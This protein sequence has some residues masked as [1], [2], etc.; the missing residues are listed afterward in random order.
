MG[1]R[2]RSIKRGIVV[3]LAASMLFSSSGTGILAEKD[4]AQVEAEAAENETVEEAIVNAEASEGEEEKA[5]TAEPTEQPETKQEITETEANPAEEPKAKPEPAKPEA[6]PEETPETKA[7]TAEPETKPGPAETE[8]KSEET[9]ETKAEP[10]TKPEPAETEAD[11]EETPDTEAELGTKPE[12]AETEADP[13]ETP[14]TESESAE[15][16]TEPEGTPEVT[17]SEESPEWETALEENTEEIETEESG[18]AVNQKILYAADNSSDDLNLFVTDV[19]IEGAEREEDGSYKVIPEQP[20]EIKLSFAERTDLQ[21]QGNVLTYQ[22]PN[23]VTPRAVTDSAMSPP[24]QIEYTDDEGKEQAVDVG[25]SYSISGQIMTIT[26]V[27]NDPNHDKYEACANVYM[28]ITTEATISAENSRK[29][30]DFGNEKKITV[31]AEDVHE[32]T[33]EKEGTYDKETGNI[34]YTVE[35]K[36]KG[37]NTNVAVTDTLKASEGKICRLSYNGDLKASSDKEETVAFSTDNVSKTGF[38]CTIPVMKSGE[39]VTL[40]YS[41]A[42]D[43]DHLNGALDPDEAQNDITATSSE[44]NEVTPDTWKPAQ[45]EISH[46]SINKWRGEWLLNN[47]DIRWW[48]IALNDDYKG[49]LP[50][51]VTDWTETGKNQNGSLMPGNPQLTCQGKGLAV[52]IY[53]KGSENQEV[54]EEEITVAWEDL[55]VSGEKLKSGDPYKRWTYRIPEKYRTGNYRCVINYDAGVKIDDNCP[56]DSQILNWAE[57]SYGN[58]SGMDVHI[59]N[60]TFGKEAV[61]VT[62][63]EV[64]WRLRINVPAA[65]LTECVV[66]DTLPSKN[67]LKDGNWKMVYDTL[68]PDSIEVTGMLPGETYGYQ[69]FEENTNAGFILTFSYA[70]GTG[71]EAT[72]D[73]KS[74]TLVITYKTKN[75]PE[76]MQYAQ[77]MGGENLDLQK[78]ENRVKVNETSD[79]IGMA[80]IS[81]KPQLQKTFVK[82]E[83]EKNGQEPP[84]TE[85]VDGIEYPVYEYRI[86][87]EGVDRDSITISDSFDTR[88]LKYKEGSGKI[89]AQGYTLYG[90]T[91]EFDGSSKGIVDAKPVA[92]GVEFHISKIAWTEETEAQAAIYYPVYYF[93]YRLIV[94]DE[95]ALKNLKEAALKGDT[96]ALALDNTA[97]ATLGG[98]TLTAVNKEVT[99][100][101]DPLDKTYNLPEGSA[102]AEFTIDVNSGAVQMG[103]EG[104]VIVTDVM[105]PNLRYLS[106]T[107]KITN[108]EGVELS[109]FSS[110]L[111]PDADGNNVLTIQGL[112]NQTHIVIQ[113]QARILGK[114]DVPI[115][116]TAKVTGYIGSDMV[117]ETVHVTSAGSGGGKIPSIF[118]YK[119][120]EA[121]AQAPLAGAKFR[122]ES[123]DTAMNRWQSVRDK[124]GK[125]V[126]VTTG[127]DGKAHLMGDQGLYG[128]TLWENVEYRLVEIEA[129]AGCDIKKDPVEFT[130]KNQPE[131]ADEYGNGDTIDI[132]N[133]CENFHIFKKD[134]DTGDL[135]KDA[136][137]TLTGPQGENSRTQTYISDAKGL[138]SFK[139]LVPGIYSLKETEAPEKYLLDE[140]EYQIAIMPDLSVKS[141]TAGLTFTGRIG[142]ITGTLLNEKIPLGSLKISKHVEGLEK[143]EIRGRK[144]LFT[145]KRK[146]EDG[147]SYFDAEGNASQKEICHEV[148]AN[149]SIT[150]ANL[151]LGEYYVKELAGKAEIEGYVLE[152]S[153]RGSVLVTV[154]EGKIAE[155]VVTNTY[156]KK[157]A[158]VKVLKVDE[159][160]PSVGLA[161]ALLQVYGQDGK[162]K[163][164]WKSGSKAHLV[165]GLE[166]NE[167]YLL[168]E[169]EA[170]DGYTVMKDLRFVIDEKG[171]VTSKDM[172]INDE[173]ALLVRN[174]KTPEPETSEPETFESE[175]SE[176]E[177]PQ[178]ETPESETSEP[179]TPQPGSIL[180]KKIVTFNGYRIKLDKTFYVALF[181]DAEG[182]VRCSEAMALEISGGEN[183]DGT[184]VVQFT[185]LPYGT[186][187]VLETEQDGSLFLGED[188]GIEVKAVI[189]NGTVVLSE[190]NQKAEVQ[191]NNQY[192]AMVPNGYY[193]EE[194]ETELEI[195]SETEFSLQPETGIESEKKD[196][197]VKTGDTT[198]YERYLLLLL[199]SG[200]LLNVML[201]RRKS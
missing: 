80:F 158:E 58:K 15:T 127:P 97:T 173:G 183:S 146:T 104:P 170:P 30:I 178:P 150:L 38:T 181:Q 144:F 129:P 49:N 74:R 171:K 195:E 142:N 139:N 118:L 9:P 66:K 123:R 24:L 83:S 78:H 23:G 90:E 193:I 164:E 39:T 12:Q 187:Y 182:T 8:A 147:W 5:E 84:A 174:Q 116:N 184:A 130:I 128:W 124:E 75:N 196:T 145:V 87:I 3:L 108:E 109:G 60:V 79:A 63:D 27:E 94:K 198:D 200:L 166:V 112:P 73:G 88:Y 167:E 126:T 76:W 45:N 103:Q 115:Q 188:M 136:R 68:V 47:H 151:P 51:T 32:I 155:A 81:R 21:F 165:T 99:Y 154:E 65:G 25:A 140:T 159:A 57:D 44:D 131:Y 42:V 11:T 134:A 143:N 179:E 70:A 111:R 110:F 93:T 67:I 122:L 1:I 41:A 191:I 31:V 69:N 2:R 148:E 172:E 180:V 113:Y 36:S 29:E 59:T 98:Q 185:D 53:S 176:P 157:L 22:F 177:T 201:K 162:V 6:K 141:E 189:T 37:T 100:T 85:T 46:V 61:R 138:L 192:Q 137:F 56:D 190:Q 186:Y 17:E 120:A 16:E 71:L 96:G 48:C 18:Q 72:G 95:E 153:D 52:R 106:E 152:I 169:A 62:S 133:V 119:H 54:L 91:T 197:A 168:H 125:D 55:K 114:G 121:S 160:N 102:V 117:D 82:P 156:Q 19:Q 149:G 35:I 105:S 77:E 92:A 101:Y 107:L 163:A 43:Y 10:E 34:D 199:I 4:S 14:E 86:R 13:E 28:F 89:V 50:E 33:L 132:S 7:E 161:G 26:V 194:P 135:L 20:Y 40:T 175:T 64:T